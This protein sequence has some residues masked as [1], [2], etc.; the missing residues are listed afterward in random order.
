VGKVDDENELDED[1]EE[2]ARHPEVHPGGAEAAVRDEEGAHPA[3]DDEEV[4]QAPEPVLQAGPGIMISFCSIFG[5][6]DRV[7]V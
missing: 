4:L 3:T 1:E 6:Y 5:R 2:A 7:R